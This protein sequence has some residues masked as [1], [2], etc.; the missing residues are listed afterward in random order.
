MGDNIQRRIGARIRA[1][2]T[3]QGLTVAEVGHRIGLSSTQVAKYEI[4]EST[5]SVCTLT[6]I[7][8][9][10]SVPVASLLDEIATPLVAN[11]R[12]ALL[13]LEYNKLNPES[14][15]LLI[16]IAKSLVEAGNRYLLA[17]E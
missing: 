12:V 10:L 13:L 8:R 6:E 11:R 1:E 17:A 16:C 7:A 3:Q 5:I 4:G 2:R 15:A 9:V 14:Q